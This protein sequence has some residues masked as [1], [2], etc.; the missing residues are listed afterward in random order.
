MS[1]NIIN[2]FPLLDELAK[3]P[4]FT[5]DSILVQSIT[6][7]EEMGLVSQD[8]K[9][10]LITSSLGLVLMITCLEIDIYPLSCCII[11]FISFSSAI[12]N[13]VLANSTSIYVCSLIDFVESQTP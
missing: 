13:G 3:M 11:S 2:Y 5:I 10:D 7:R 8:S 9:M 12:C 1:S 6:I 4:R